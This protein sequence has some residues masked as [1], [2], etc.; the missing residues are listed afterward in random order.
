MA[1]FAELSASSTVLRVVVIDNKD[2]EQDG[3]ED[4]T[5]GI[6]LC[7]TLFGANTEWRQT[8]YNSNFRKNYA[9]VGFS[10]D[11]T[12]DA[13][14]PPQPHPSWSLNA[15]TCQWQAPKPKPNDGKSYTWDEALLRW[16]ALS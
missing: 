14:I 13:F 6:E 4:E 5:K 7:K 10:Y 8:S 16:V 1:H 9:G 12:L 11:E 3:I 15:E 2:I